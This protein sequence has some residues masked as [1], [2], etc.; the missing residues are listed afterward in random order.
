MSETEDFKKRSDRYGHKKVKIDTCTSSGKNKSSK[1]Y[2][3]ENY[4]PEK[5]DTKDE[6]STKKHIA[7]LQDAFKARKSVD[8]SKVETLMS[9]TLY[10]RRNETLDGETVS[11]ILETYPWLRKSVKPFLSEFTRISS[12]DI[13]VEIS[14][15][16][17]KYGNNIMSLV[18]GKVK[19]Y[20]LFMNLVE[21][22]GTKDEKYSAACCTILGIP[23]LFK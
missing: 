4:C 13:S 7:W 5:P 16:L 8:V 6:E 15:F 23:P 2:G 18:M 11:K 17:D 21:A 9:L 12:L 10:M 19:N 20:M 22:E 14:T 1:M 3:F